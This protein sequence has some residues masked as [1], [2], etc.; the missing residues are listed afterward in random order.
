MFRNRLTGVSGS[1]YDELRPVV[2]EAYNE[3]YSFVGN[4][5]GSPTRTY[6]RYETENYNGSDC[7]TGS[8]DIYKLGYDEGSQSVC[9]TAGNDPLVKSTLLRHGNYDYYNKAVVWD[10]A[11]PNHAIPSSFYLSSKPAFFG[12]LP[13]PAVGPDLNP[14]VGTIPAQ[15]RYEN[16]AV[17]PSTLAGDLNADGRRT[18]TDLHWLLEMLIGARPVNLATADLDANGQLTLAD[19]RA[20]V[21][22]II[23][24]GP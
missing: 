13:W 16:A 24:G 19:L 18:L 4:V 14:M 5:L 15:V 7:Y 3:Y 10:P 12:S 21:L 20:L 11:I 23:G 9:N 2:I 1:Y 17:I 6:T 22:L 8:P